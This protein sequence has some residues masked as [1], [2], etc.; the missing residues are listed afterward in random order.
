MNADRIARAYR[1]IEYLTFG[2]TLQQCRVAHLPSLSDKQQVLILGE[3]DGRFLD[4]L[5]NANPKVLVDV[6]DS[7]QQMV[8]LAQARLLPSNRPRVRFFHSDAVANPFHADYYNVCAVNFFLDCLSSAE[9]QAIV[10]KIALALR[11]G[12]HLIVGEFQVPSRGLKRLH[13][14]VWLRTMYLFFRLTTGL[15]ATNIPDYQAMLGSAGF[16]L[17]RQQTRRFGLIAAQLWRKAC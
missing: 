10:A 8:D 15:T 1:W 7:S 17:V 16:V 14:L 3:G 12:G 6:F 2:H 11:P 5:V 13:A 4:A 9:T